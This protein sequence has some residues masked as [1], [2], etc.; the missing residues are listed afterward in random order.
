MA[1]EFEITDLLRI[2]DKDKYATTVAAFEIIDMMEM[3]S[4]PKKLANRKP[5]VKALYALSDDLVKFDYI[6]DEQRDALLESLE[7]PEARKSRLDDVFRKD[8]LAEA[9]LENPAGR[10]ATYSDEE[11]EADDDDKF[12]DFG[13]DTRRLRDVDGDDDN[14]EEDDSFFRDDTKASTDDDDDDDDDDDNSFD[15]DDDDDDS[16]FDD[17]DDSD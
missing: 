8:P 3:I 11:G 7:G 13:S 6:S 17:D 16:D 5:A 15:D 10:D 12:N 4:I 2:S 14:E 1:R 9:G